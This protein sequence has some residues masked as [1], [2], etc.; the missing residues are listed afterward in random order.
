LKFLASVILGVESTIFGRRF[1]PVEVVA[2]IYPLDAHRILF[3][4]W[5]SKF[6][7]YNVSCLYNKVSKPQI[8]S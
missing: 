8:M 6:S 5:Y 3:N 4:V 2:V 7:F 1:R